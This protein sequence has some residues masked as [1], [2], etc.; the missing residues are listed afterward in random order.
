MVPHL[1]VAP[2]RSG[3]DPLRLWL[4]Y[5]ETGVQRWAC[6]RVAAPARPRPPC[7]QPNKHLFLEGSHHDP[8]WHP[9]PPPPVY[10]T[11]SVRLILPVKTLVNTFRI[12]DWSQQQLGR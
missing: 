7:C 9:T 1:S 10:I 5:V 3:C 6:V 8:L 11:Q 4:P 2:C 12:V